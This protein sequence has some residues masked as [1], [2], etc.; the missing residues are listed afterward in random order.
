MKR[1]NDESR[2]PAFRTAFLSLK[3]DMTTVEFA[4]K[5]G[6]SRATV[7]FYEAGERIPDA[8][9][10]AKIAQVCDVSTDYLLGFTTDKAKKPSPIDKLGIS[11]KAVS[12]LSELQ[13]RRIGQSFSPSSIEAMAEGQKSYARLAKLFNEHNTDALKEA[14]SGAEV[15]SLDELKDLFIDSTTEL[16][17]DLD[18]ASASLV[19]DIINLLLETEEELHII[20]NLSLFIF[21]TSRSTERIYFSVTPLDKNGRHGGLPV[22]FDSSQIMNIPL[23]EAEK[24][25]YKLK[26][27]NAKYMVNNVGRVKTEE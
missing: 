16:C 17:K 24:G 12:I 9:G 27:R 11:E 22:S 13:S 5:L 19:L 7:G 6:M 1:V 23:V 3:G 2:F 21:S 18:S 14:L 15:H 26:E 10:V 20:R 25:I 4:K 8:L